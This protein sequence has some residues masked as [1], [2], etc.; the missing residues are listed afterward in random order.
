MHG[1]L[2][3][4]IYMDQPKGYKQTRIENL[5]CRIKKYLYRLKW[6]PRMWYI[7]YDTF[8]KRK[9]FNI[10]EVDHFA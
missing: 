9:C 7:K 1:D 8:M 2:N 10:G 5:I 6:V 3:E 4:E